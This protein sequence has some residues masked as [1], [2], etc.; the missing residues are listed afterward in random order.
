[1]IVDERYVL[2]GSTNWSVEA[3]ETVLVPM[4]WLARGVGDLDAA[5]RAHR[6]GAGVVELSAR[7][8][9]SI[10]VLGHARQELGNPIEALRCE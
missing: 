3:P 7:T 6:R 10:S 5:C 4:A 8:G 1:L 2:E 9:L